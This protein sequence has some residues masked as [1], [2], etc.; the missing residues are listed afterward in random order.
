MYHGLDGLDITG[1]SDKLLAEIQSKQLL[2]PLTA[3][4][5]CRKYAS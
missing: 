3:K 1:Y 5:D 2:T 4:H